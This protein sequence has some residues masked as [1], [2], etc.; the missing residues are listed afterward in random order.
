MGCISSL[1]DWTEIR[2]YSFKDDHRQTLYG[3]EHGTTSRSN[4]CLARGSSTHSPLARLCA[5]VPR[6]FALHGHHQQPAQAIKSPCCGQSVALH[7]QQAACTIGLRRTPAQQ[8]DGTEAG[9]GN[10]A[11]QPQAKRTIGGYSKASG[12]ILIRFFRCVI[13]RCDPLDFADPASH[14]YGQPWTNPSRKP[15]THGSGWGGI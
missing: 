3:Y 1:S 14:G 6:R 9:G 12:R 11:T 15:I 10:Q 8:V 7:P 2:L 5:L 4:R 13:N